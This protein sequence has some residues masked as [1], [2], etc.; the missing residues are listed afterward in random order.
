MTEQNKNNL[1]KFG[2]VAIFGISAFAALIAFIGIINGVVAN[3][4]ESFYGWVGGFNLCI[5]GVFSMLCIRDSSRKK[6]RSK[7]F[8][9]LKNWRGAQDGEGEGLLIP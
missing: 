2:K 3:G 6:N 4:L 1:V 7:R 9:K 8:S 5:E